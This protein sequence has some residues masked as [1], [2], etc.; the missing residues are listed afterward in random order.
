MKIL[1]IVNMVMP[2]LANYLQVTTGSSGTWMFDI[3]KRLGESPDYDF[4][5]ACVFGKQFRKEA[6][7]NTMYYVLP[8]SGKNML[9]YTREYE[10]IWRDVIQEFKPDIVHIHGTEYSHGLACMRACPSMKYVISIQGILSRIRDVD[11]AGLSWWEAFRYRTIREYL[12]CNGMVEAHLLHC[13]NAKYEQEMIQRSSYANCVNTW[14]TSITKSIN[15][16]IKIFKLEYNLREEFYTADK[17]DFNKIEP[18]S[19]FTNPGGTPLKGMHQLFRALAIVKKQFPDVRLY[20]PG[21]GD[22]NGRLNVTSG[23]TKYLKYLVS[24]LSIE[25]SINFLGRQ[26]GPEMMNRMRSAHVVVVPSAIEGTSL[27]L[28]EAMYLGCP[29][30]ASFRG[31]MADFITDKVDGYLYD[32]QEYPYLAA[33]IMEVFSSEDLSSLSKAA[34]QKSMQAHD[35]NRNYQ[36]YVNMYNSIFDN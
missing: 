25:D 7:N 8:G 15:P 24:K 22:G 20:V 23:Y 12:K 36:A 35:R 10:E 21:M 5:V 31:G 32:F 9:F 34:I 4:A 18:Y 27:V 14:D 26:S 2:E 13:K 29:C 19:I 28:R 6:V 11:F 16:S 3:A 1:W 17:W 33:R 30:I